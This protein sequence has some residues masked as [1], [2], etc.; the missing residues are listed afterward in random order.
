VA[1]VALL[2][3]LAMAAGKNFGRARGGGLDAPLNALPQAALGEGPGAAAPGAPAGPFAG[4]AA[5][6]AARAPDISSLSP[7]ER[8]DRLFD[9]VMRLGAEGKPD[10]VQL[11]AGMALMQYE[12]M[13]ALD[14]DLRYDMGRVAEV[15]GR[16]EIARAQADTIL[17][18]SP[19]HL[20]GL[21]LAAK[22]ASMRGDAAALADYN[23][24][25]AAAAPAERARNLEEYQRHV[26]DIDDALAKAGKP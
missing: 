26:Q 6:G 23:R 19:T 16:P 15:A 9:R 5:P 7:R 13:G 18:Q 1:F 14:A 10:S 25:L 17:Q 24:R 12:T 20:L 21:V 3:L 4:G 2:A 11:F 8:A 22:A